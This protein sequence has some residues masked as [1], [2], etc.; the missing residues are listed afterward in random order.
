MCT[1]IKGESKSRKMQTKIFSCKGFLEFICFV[2]LAVRE[3]MSLLGPKPLDSLLWRND[4]VF[5]LVT[6]S[7]CLSNL[8]LFE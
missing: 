4:F 5:I 3:S 6:R 2:T 7:V 1:N 8:S